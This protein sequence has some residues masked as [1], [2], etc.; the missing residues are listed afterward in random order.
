MAKPKR[1]DTGPTKQILG[2]TLVLMGVC[3]ILAFVV[4]GI[5]LFNIQ[6]LRHTEFESRAI[7]QQVRETMVS[8]S[9]GTIFD[10]N[11]T[12]LAQNG[13]VENVFI[14]PFA[15][16]Y[17]QEDQEMIARRLSEILEVDEEM[18]L[19]RMENTASQFQTIRTQIERDLADQVR[20]FV[21]EYSLKSVFL[22]P[23]TRRYF[24]RERSASHILGFVGADG[25]GMGYGV[26]GSYDSYLSGVSGRV[27]RLKSATGVDMIRPDYESY[28]AAQP[29]DDVHLTIDINVQQIM[30][31]HMNQA[32]RDFDLQYGG[33][34]IAM[35]P[36]TGAILGMVSLEDFNPNSHGRLSEERMEA[37]REIH[38]DNDEAFWA[39]VSEELHYSWRN[40]TIGYTYEPG[41]TFKIVTLAIALEEGIIT[42]DDT[43]TFYCRGYMHVDG[44]T[45]PLNCWRRTGHGALNLRGVMQQSCNVGTVELAM[46]IGADIFFQYLRD[47]GMMETT[48]IDLGGEM[49][50]SIWSEEQW[51][52]YID[53]GNFSS[54]AA[55][56]FGQTFTMTPLRLA[57]AT[58]ALVNGGHILE[59]FV[60]SQVTA[61]D[62]SIVR[63]NETQSRRQVISRE[64]SLAVL[65]IM[66]S[67]VADETM[68]T[69][70][71]AYVQG[72]RIGGKT[73][74]STDT[75]IEALTGEKEYILSFVSA[76]PIEDPQ[77]VLLVSLQSPGPNNTTYVSGGQ[78]AAPIVGKMMAEILPYL[79][80]EPQFGPEVQRIN[81]QV[82]YVRRRTAEEARA[83]L[84][85]EGFSVRIQG[86]GERVLDQM[87][88]GG[89]I[90][91]SGTE[92]ILYMDSRRPEDM[93]TVPDVTGMRYDEARATL[94]TRG[95]YV[96][97]SGARSNHSAVQVYSQSRPPADVVRRGTVIQIAMI[98]T[99]R[100]RSF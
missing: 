19:T 55:A 38:G 75:V 32:V 24:P 8:A 46:E 2:R 59:P 18:I 12:V 89:A 87:P 31:R 14:S 61:Q 34:A 63:T 47:F 51:D 43:R 42:M 70:S 66:E 28:F 23:T 85:A 68:G 6:I 7:A 13:S 25:A 64:T 26:E 4:L 67:I 62:G 82:P 3:G 41:S 72:F 100:D 53:H 86:T 99:T 96:R 79:G 37:L 40:K 30:E 90:V 76:A 48:G 33:F 35:D 77:I 36:Q 1:G 95:L 81:V 94:E 91:V 92:V 74:T 17:H 88:A 44:R 78:M 93:V 45:E 84:E 54:L 5:Q 80:V 21:T 83:E 10:A 97:R 65:D 16:N 22:E 73:G 60:V 11:G 20:E 71:N 15:M 39:A 29:G 58:S 9:R 52:F 49:L 69:G 27:V 50:G 98:D 56:S 57:T